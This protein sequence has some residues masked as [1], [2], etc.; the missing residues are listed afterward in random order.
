MP[1]EP[2]LLEKF[3]I[4]LI[5]SIHQRNISPRLNKIGSKCR[6]YPSCSNYGLMAIEKYG[7]M[8]GWI[9]TLWRIWECNPWNKESHIDYP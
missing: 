9:K 7:F 6:F 3:S 1:R 8:K 2:N 4:Y 5:V